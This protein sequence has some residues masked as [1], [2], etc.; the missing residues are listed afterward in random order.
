MSVPIGGGTVSTLASGQSPNG[1]GVD[2]IVVDAASVY[3]TT[4]DGTVKRVAKP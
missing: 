1:V 3:W 2:V 4:S